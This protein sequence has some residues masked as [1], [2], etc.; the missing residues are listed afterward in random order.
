[1]PCYFGR[2]VRRK[3]ID[4]SV[5]SDIYRMTILYIVLPSLGNIV[6]VYTLICTRNVNIYTLSYDSIQFLVWSTK[7]T[8]HSIMCGV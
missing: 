3:E 7:S 8:C 5:K 4:R 6:N 2:S 1:M